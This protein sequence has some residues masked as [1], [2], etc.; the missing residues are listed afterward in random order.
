MRCCSTPTGI[1]RPSRGYPAGPHS[2][3]R[4]RRVRRAD[5]RPRPA[6]SRSLPRG[7]RSRASLDPSVDAAAH[8]FVSTSVTWAMRPS[9]ANSMTSVPADD[10]G[11]SHPRLPRSC[12]AD[13]RGASGRWSSIPGSR[14]WLRGSQRSGRRALPVPRCHRGPRRQ[15]RRHPPPSTP[16]GAPPRA[17]AHST[18]ARRARRRRLVQASAEPRVRD[19]GLDS[20]RRRHRSVSASQPGS[21][22]VAG[23]SL[24]YAFRH[25]HEQSSG[26]T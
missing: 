26:N 7:C 19:R 6:R 4:R 16:P 23:S 14:A 21:S 18:P 17:P 24:A 12:T 2:Q 9:A 13:L 20:S 5:Q 3:R 11:G 8:E 10:S 15:R 25:N 22:R 1:G